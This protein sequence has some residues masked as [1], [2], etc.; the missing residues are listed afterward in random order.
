[1][2]RIVLKIGAINFR[3]QRAEYGCK[4]HNYVWNC[5]QF[6][7]QGLERFF[8]RWVIL[9]TTCN[10]CILMGLATMP[11][12]LY[13]IFLPAAI[14]DWFKKHHFLGGKL[15]KFKFFKIFI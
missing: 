8:L 5:G 6:L 12:N 10:V 11:K 13:Q 1:M 7:K 4:L 3:L 9:R 2:C 14:K 15:E